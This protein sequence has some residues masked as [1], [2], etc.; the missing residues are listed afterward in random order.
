MFVGTSKTEGLGD[1]HALVLKANNLGYRPVALLD[2]VHP[3]GLHLVLGI[4]IPIVPHGIHRDRLRCCLLGGEKLLGELPLN[5]ESLP[6]FVEGDVG[7]L[8]PFRHTAIVKDHINVV[9]GP[10]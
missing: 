4:T 9:L 5:A 10:L 6:T 2:G 8:R 1:A 3:C 7:L